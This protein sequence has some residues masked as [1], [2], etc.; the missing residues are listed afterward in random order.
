MNMAQSRAHLSDT[1]KGILLE[2]I[3]SVP[4][5]FDER[6][7]NEDLRTLCPHAMRRELQRARLR[8]LLEATPNPWIA[9]RIRAL[10][11]ALAH[12]RH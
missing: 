7:A 4:T 8:W 2:V 5:G 9:R 10:R 12:A 3:C 11:E 6:W 1:V